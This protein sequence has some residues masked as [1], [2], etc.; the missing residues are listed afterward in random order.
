MGYVFVIV[1]MQ[2]VFILIN[3]CGSIKKVLASAL[4]FTMVI[5]TASVLPT[6]QNANAA[7]YTNAVEES[8]YQFKDGTLTLLSGVEF[9]RNSIS[10]DFANRNEVK[11]VVAQDGV[12]LVGDC[13][14]MFYQLGGLEKV[15]LSKADTSE[16][17]SMSSMFS[18]CS[19]LK[20]ID[21]SGIDTSN[22]EDMSDMFFFCT[23]L[24][25]LDLSS[26]DTSSLTNTYRMFMDCDKLTSLDL[27][28]FNTNNI[29][30]A[31]YMFAGCASLSKLVLGN[32]INIT[33][34]MKL[35][36]GGSNYTGWSNDGSRNTVSGDGTYAVLSGEGVYQIV[37]APTHVIPVAATCTT[38][39]NIEYWTD[40][41]G[42]YYSDAKGT[43]QID[44]ADTVIPA[45]GHAY[46]Y[47]DSK[48][49]KNHT[50]LCL[51][52]GDT[53]TEKHTYKNGYCVCGA[54]ELHKCT[55]KIHLDGESKVY[56]QGVFMEDSTL[57]L[58]AP[59]KYGNK[60]FKC[61]RIG[62]P[63]GEKVGEYPRYAF[64]VTKSVD[65]Y[66]EYTDE[67]NNQELP[68]F[69]MIKTAQTT[70][71]DKNAIKFRALLVT[72]DTEDDELS[73]VGI[74]YATNKLLG[75]TGDRNLN[76][77]KNS[78][79]DVTGIMKSN[80]NGKIKRV[81]YRSSGCSVFDFNYA[82]SVY[83]D[84]YVYAIPYVTYKNDDGEYVTR[85]SDTIAVTY[86]TVEA[87]KENQ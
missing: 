73:E 15:D 28:N 25:D 21:L 33:A 53:A 80:S 60:Y 50:K 31:K 16:V 18:N 82:V 8:A 19:S 49:G 45:K 17:T 51:T 2:E 58:T 44:K 54:K 55:I 41:N 30:N 56:A 22:V 32:S 38:D 1:N 79:F 57:T 29:E 10:W 75:Y 47:T 85:Y 68:V 77:L 81:T 72:N 66:A 6:T 23:E 52:C 84:A 78:S 74:I 62:S 37:K 59:V 34:D 87:Y 43:V 5:G 36:N 42:N 46:V 67:Y 71:N 12:K 27:S 11:E 69:E 4:A 63:D 7:I 20:T 14:F 86:N 40:E 61:W 65:F 83:T 9:G 24:E 70:V 48:D 64:D 3:F 76:L 39:G 13:S 26:F 35:T